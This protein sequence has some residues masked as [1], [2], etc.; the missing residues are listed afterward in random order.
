MDVTDQ[1]VGKVTDPAPTYV[2]LM[3][4]RPLVRKVQGRDLGP[5]INH[6]VRTCPHF[7]SPIGR[8]W[9]A[10]CLDWARTIRPACR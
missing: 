5:P 8:V 10:N 4:G 3:Q 7:Q 2:D 9:S 6:S 1:A